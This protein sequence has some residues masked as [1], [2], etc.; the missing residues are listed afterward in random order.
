MLTKD[1]FT[2]K[3]AA[4]LTGASRQIIRIYTSTYQRYFSTE[5]APDQSG[6]QRRFTPADVK[7]IRFIYTRTAEH[8]L[9]HEQV[10]AALAAGE[11][12]Q[13]AWEAPERPQSAASAYD[14]PEEQQSASA[15][16]VPVERLQAAHALMQDAQRR[17]QQAAEQVQALTERLAQLERE[18]G[19]AQGELQA[20]KQLR[21]RRPRWLQWLVGGPGAE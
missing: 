10:Q 6:Q 13:F 15:A 11:L 1:Y 5:G 21:P 4:E 19:A 14:S 17:E 9:T 12:E 7:L 18:L 3:E 8:K 2:T 20:Y 16:L